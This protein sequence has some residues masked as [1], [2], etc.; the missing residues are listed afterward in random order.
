MI[1]LFYLL[2]MGGLILLAHILT[3]RYPAGSVQRR[4]AEIVRGLALMALPLAPIIVFVVSILSGDQMVEMNAI[5][6]K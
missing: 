4:R 2:F 6:Y 5:P 3:T 1:W